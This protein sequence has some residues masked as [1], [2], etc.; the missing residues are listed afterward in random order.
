MQDRNYPVVQNFDQ[1]RYLGTWY[2]V[3]RS[4]KF[5][6][7][8][9][10]AT[11]AHYSMNGDYIRVFNSDIGYKDDGKTLQNK[12]NYA[13]GWAVWQ[14]PERKEATL[15]VKFSVFQPTYAPYHIID[16]DYDTFAIVLSAAE[17]G[18]ICNGYRYIW[19]L[20]REKLT[21][22]SKKVEALTNK[23]KEFL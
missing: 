14:N 5:R 10:E 22:G 18:C 7:G 17:R 16:T 13:E 3:Y 21:K 9:G 23:V 1:K 6:F 2:E 12:R 20:S 11:T 4:K 8:R 15:G 19:I